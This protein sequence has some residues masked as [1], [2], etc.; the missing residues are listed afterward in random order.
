V[1]GSHLPVQGPHAR[2]ANLEALREPTFAMRGDKTPRAL[3][4]NSCSYSLPALFKPGSRSPC[5][6]TRWTWGIPMNRVR[7]GRD[8]VLAVQANRCA[9]LWRSGT[10]ALPAR[11]GSRSYYTFT[12]WMWR[13]SMNRSRT[14]R[15]AVSEGSAAARWKIDATI[16]AHADRRGCPRSFPT[17]LD[18]TPPPLFAIHRAFLALKPESSPK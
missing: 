7:D 4:R 10:S 15:A 14:R 2:F 16:H 17:R 18:D 5:T 9:R 3:N 8:R 1:R 13:R 12:R 11:P 6:R